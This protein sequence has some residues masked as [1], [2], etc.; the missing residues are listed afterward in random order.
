EALLDGVHPGLDGL[1]ALGADVDL[2]GG[3]VADDDHREAGGEAVVGLQP[4]NLCRDLL[5]DLGGEGLAVNHSCR[6]RLSLRSVA[7]QFRS[8]SRAGITARS[9]Q[10]ETCPRLRRSSG[11]YRVLPPR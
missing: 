2:A 1:A 8:G 7:G 10:T 3:V 9:A 6:H 5:P 4:G 11:P